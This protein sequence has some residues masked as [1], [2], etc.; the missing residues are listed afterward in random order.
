MNL[1]LNRLRFKKLKAIKEP[2]LNRNFSQGITLKFLQFVHN[3]I[4][5]LSVLK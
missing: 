2:V 1:Q 4:P 5:V 3:L